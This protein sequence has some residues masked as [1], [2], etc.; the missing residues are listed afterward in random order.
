MVGNGRH[1]SFHSPVTWCVCVRTYVAI[2]LNMA[3]R[4]ADPNEEAEYPAPYFE[5]IVEALKSVRC[6][7][8]FAASGRIDLNNPVLTINGLPDKVGL[9]LS[10][11]QAKQIAE[12][13]SR[14]PFSRGEDT[15]I[16]TNVRCTWQLDPAQLS[17][18]NSEWSEKLDALL[19]H[20]K[21]NLGCNTDQHI[22]C[23]LYKLLLYEP[24]G[25]FKVND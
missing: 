13:C 10:Q 19:V 12:N 24:G 5:A 7:G 4:S 21:T 25:F 6:P 3:D 17:I 23:E 14:A 22:T 16:D 18:K 1:T 15:I 9:P 2:C 20:L 8:H 11:H